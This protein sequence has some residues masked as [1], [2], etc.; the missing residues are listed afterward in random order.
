MSEIQ[1]VVTMVEKIN[2]Y[3]ERQRRMAF[4]IATQIQADSADCRAGK[5]KACCFGP[6]VLV[7]IGLCFYFSI[8]TFRTANSPDSLTLTQ[9]SYL[10]I[11]LIFL[12]P[13]I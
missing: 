12:W 4:K 10:L 13:Q 7:F 1:Q 3:Q 5:R 9:V 11:N 6:I 8:S 2:D